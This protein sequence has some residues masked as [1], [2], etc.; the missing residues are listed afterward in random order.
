MSKRSLEDSH[1]GT[2]GFVKRRVSSAEVEIAERDVSNVDDSLVT[3]ASSCQPADDHELCSRCASL[4][5][6]DILSQGPREWW[7]GRLIFRIERSRSELMNSPCSFCR[8]IASIMPPLTLESD[9]EEFGL[10][11]LQR[12]GRLTS[13]KDYGPMLGVTRMTERDFSKEKSIQ[14]NGCLLSTSPPNCEANPAQIRGRLIDPRSTDFDLLRYWVSCCETHHRAACGKTNWRRPAMFRL[15]DCTTMKVVNAPPDC[16]YSALSYVCGPAASNASSVIDDDC[17]PTNLQRT[18]GDAIKVTK[19]LSLQYIWI[20]KYCIY[21]NDE[22]KRHV[23]IRQMDLVYKSAYITIIAAGGSDPHF[24]L[25]GVSETPR[26]PQPYAMVGNHLM[27]STMS[28]PET[29][30][31]TS[32][33]MTRGWTYQESLFSPRRIVFT[34]QQVYF[35]CQATSFCE[36]Y[37][38]TAT[39]M[40][41]VANVFNSVE[42]SRRYPWYLLERLAV[43]STRKLSFETD[44]LIA[45]LG[46]L[47]DYEDGEHPIYHHWGTPILPPI[48]RDSGYDVRKDRVLLTKQTTSEGFVAGMCWLNAARGKRRHGFPSWSWTGWDAPIQRTSPPYRHGLAFGDG[49]L[50]VSVELCDGLMLSWEKFCESY[51]SNESLRDIS[52]LSQY[53]HIQAWMIPLRLDLFPP[54]SSKVPAQDFG[55]SKPY[56]AI[57]QDEGYSIYSYLFLLQQIDNEDC[58]SDLAST[59]LQSCFG[60]I[61]GMAQDLKSRA[62]PPVLVVQDRGSHFERVGHLFLGPYDWIESVGGHLVSSRFWDMS[63]DEEEKWVGRWLRHKQLRRIRLG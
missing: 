10:Y 22:S 57:L 2:F 41:T 46:V 43:Y 16:R 12:N 42:D 60:I 52:S 3:A 24:G 27:V 11:I 38:S 47:H 9:L 13:F 62:P 30:I 56:W 34:E 14:E 31:E 54:L 7:E 17:V 15:I 37:A 51:L 25:P 33:Y 5:M 44:I 36:T 53:I 4:D 26:S 39:T 20:D 55:H 59:S 32:P 18:I 28:D 29:L 63:P 49:S 45:F 48:A 1:H 40:S 35:E 6:D 61:P 8:L 50:E 58:Q 19:E 23:Q 21:Q